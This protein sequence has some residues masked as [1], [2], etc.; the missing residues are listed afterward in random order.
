[1]IR[2]WKCFSRSLLSIEK[3]DIG[4][5]PDGLCLAVDLGIGTTL[6]DFYSL[7]KWP[8]MIDRLKRLVNERAILSEVA[9]SMRAEIP[10]GPVAFDTSKV[11]VQSLVLC[12]VSDLD[13][14]HHLP[15]SFLLVDQLVEAQSNSSTLRTT[16]GPV[17]INCSGL[18][19]IRDSVNIVLA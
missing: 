1:M 9:F 2:K 13:M 7:G 15:H 14:L 16:V 4:L 10:S 8:L 19:F 5:Y 12:K 18:F 3:S 17:I 11:Y 6:A